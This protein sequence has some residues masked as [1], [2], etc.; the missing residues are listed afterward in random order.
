MKQQLLEQTGTVIECCANSIFKVQLDSNDMVIVC[1][2]SGKIRM[3]YI[4][5]STNDKVKVEMSPYDLSKGRIVWREKP[6][7]NKP[8]TNK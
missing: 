7:F 5:I 6:N 3:K 4:Q 1:H 2:I 8:D